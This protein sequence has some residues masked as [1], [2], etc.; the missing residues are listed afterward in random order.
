MNTCSSTTWYSR[1]S[2][3]LREWRP[4]S[5]VNV[6]GPST[7]GRTAGDPAQRVAHAGRPGFYPNPPGAALPP[8]PAVSDDRGV[9]PAEPGAD[10]PPGT[11]TLRLW[12]AR[13]GRTH[14][15]LRRWRRRDGF[16]LPAGELPAR[17]RHGG[18][19]GELLFDETA[20]DAWLGGQVDLE[21]PERFDLAAF[22]LAPDDRITL[23]R[24]A[25]IIGK[26]RNTVAQH[27][28]RPSFPQAGA[29]GIYR[30]SDL[31]DYW[32][33]RT[34]HRGQARKRRAAS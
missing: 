14:D 26:A 12:A 22:G 32:N 23:G 33:S 7:I 10:L 17:G 27:L 8:R 25:T 20:L 16:P 31:F 18:G 29:D 4:R 24:F 3:P 1:C 19:R 15:Y 28:E 6:P 13:H 21:P 5:A 9:P 2:D 34:G 11:T 30:A